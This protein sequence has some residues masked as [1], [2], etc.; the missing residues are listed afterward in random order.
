MIRVRFFLILWA[1]FAFKLR[2]VFMGVLMAFSMPGWFAL[3]LA[4]HLWPALAAHDL[5]VPLAACL[6]CWFFPSARLF[7][8][9][10]LHNPF[11]AKNAA[12][13]RFSGGLATVMDW[14]DQ[15]LF[16]RQKTGRWG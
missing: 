4:R 9:A 11:T 15:R 2:A 16:G 10:G 8:W 14:T 5:A 12:R 1:V 13:P 3:H 7:R 6:I